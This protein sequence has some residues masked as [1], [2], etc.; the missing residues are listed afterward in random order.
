MEHV[1]ADDGHKF[2]YPAELATLE[3]VIRAVDEGKQIIYYVGES[4]G[5]VKPKSQRISDLAGQV[6]RFVVEG[7]RGTLLQRKVSGQRQDGLNRY[8]YLAVPSKRVNSR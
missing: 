6:W 4:L 5:I 3:E 2:N 7:E 1:K 8:E